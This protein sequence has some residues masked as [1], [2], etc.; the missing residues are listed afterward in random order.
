MFEPKVNRKRGASEPGEVAWTD[1][2]AGLLRRLGPYAALVVVG[3]G[4]TVLVYLGYRRILTSP[5][6]HLETV[7]IEGADFADRGELIR[8]SNLRSG[9]HAL[10]VDTD[11]VREKVEAHP[12]IRRARVDIEL[13]DRAVL[14]VRERKP[15]A[16]LLDDRY[17]ALDAEGRVIEAL[18]PGD[19]VE[20]LLERPL[21]TGLERSDLRTEHGRALVEAALSV[22]KLYRE[23]GLDESHPIGELHLDPLIGV[24]LVTRE[25]ATE[26]YLGWEPYRPRLARLR[27][28]RGALEQRG[29]EPRYILLNRDGPGERAVVG[30]RRDQGTDAGGR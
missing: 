18:E 23:M 11:R 8:R 20:S 17:L 27:Q 13:P 26:I 29:V 1:R 22:V 4:V 3:V 5:Y 9:R 15:S 19:P 2:A 25:R 6:F 12:W 7:R 16:V 24:T 10:L 28:L 14:R 30:P 21:L